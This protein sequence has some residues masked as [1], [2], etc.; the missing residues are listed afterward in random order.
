VTGTAAEHWDAWTPE[1]GEDD[2]IEGDVAPQRLCEPP[3]P[4]PELRRK[5]DE[6]EEEPDPTDE[7]LR[8]TPIRHEEHLNPK[9]KPKT[10]SGTLPL[11]TSASYADESGSGPAQR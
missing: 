10:T 3:L 1:D 11:P 2:L 8:T 9:S 6:D 4:P 7:I 5:D